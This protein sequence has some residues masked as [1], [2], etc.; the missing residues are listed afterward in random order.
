MTGDWFTS[1]YVQA[2]QDADPARLIALL[3]DEPTFV[4]PFSVW[5]TRRAVEA[6]CRART[7]AFSDVVATSVLEH[8]GSA[9]IRWRAQ[10]AGRDVEGIDLITA[11]QDGIGTIDVFLRPA[12]VLPA[13]YQAMTEA[14][15]C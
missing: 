9:S 1:S 10:L 15:P 4:S 8:A 11:R 7:R 6:A 12:N 13:V 5:S 3:V 14:W 2:L